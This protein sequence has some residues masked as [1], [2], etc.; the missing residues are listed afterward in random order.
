MLKILAQRKDYMGPITVELKNLPPNVT[1][2]KAIIPA[3]Q[4]EVVIQVAA[5]DSA[6]VGDKSDVNLHGVGQPEMQVTSKNFTISVRQHSFDLRFQP[7]LVRIAGG[8]TA[9]V[10]VQATRKSYQGP[11][12]V[13]MRNLPV[14][15]RAGK[16]TV[17]AGKNE[18]EI[19]LTAADTA[20]AARA[21]ALAIGSADREQAPSSPLTILVQAGLFELKMEPAVVRVNNGGK[22]K[23]KVQALR[24][25]YQGPIS[26]MVRNL[27]MA[28][29]AA[30]TTI[31]KGETAAEVEISASDLAADSDTVDVYAGGAADGSG[32]EIQSPCV[33]ISVASAGQP[34][35]FELKLEPAAATLSQGGKATFKVTVGRKGGYKGPIAL[36]LRNLPTGVVSA[37]VTVP[38][39]QTTAEIGLSAVANATV[40]TKT[41]VC[42]LGKAL[43]GGKQALAS[44]HI[45]LTVSKK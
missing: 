35:P 9:T 31:P 29:T 42:V 6:S 27:P 4:K 26:V 39:D 2:P 3:N 13:E 40:G 15:V 20:P 17:P 34:P 7:A 25:G 16:A 11:I 12:A 41:D 14:G 5:A 22:A 8:S 33:T 24:K 44:P 36:E 43:G 23:V 38:M 37:K 45:V 21:E 19:E 1:A 10:K 28:I 18:A 32:K 30:K